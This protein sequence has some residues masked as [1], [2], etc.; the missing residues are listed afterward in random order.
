M[1]IAY[2]RI[3]ELKL[4]VDYIVNTFDI[5]SQTFIISIYERN[6][7]FRKLDK[8]YIMERNIDEIIH[9]ILE[10]RSIGKKQ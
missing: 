5:D 10:N 8:R 7:P 3:L 1:Y 4:G 6:I 9:K 2:R